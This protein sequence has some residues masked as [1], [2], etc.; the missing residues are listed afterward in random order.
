M[1]KKELLK[2]KGKIEKNISMGKQQ[3]VNLQAQLLRLE[4]ALAYINE[5][6]EGKDDKQRTDN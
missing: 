5:N 2:D 4:G 3:L 1:T 6:L